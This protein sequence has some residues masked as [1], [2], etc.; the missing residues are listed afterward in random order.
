M[1][2]LVLRDT[3]G[4]LEN[5]ENIIDKIGTKMEAIIHL[6]D[7]ENDVAVL[8]KKY[9]FLTFYSVRGNNDY[10]SKT[11]EELMLRMGGKRLLLTHGHKQ[12]VYYNFYTISCWAEE[13]Q[14]DIV[15]FG[16]THIPVNDFKGSVYLFNPGSISLPRATQCPTFGILDISE[17]GVIRG[18][19]M[20][21]A[22]RDL[23]RLMRI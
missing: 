10:S 11:P 12:R 1:K 16:H 6:G 20:E 17:S 3:H 23:F 21:Y 8:K 14:A 13:Q 5:A 7:Y 9:P 19:I 4:Y 18:S 2:I 22:G 15:L